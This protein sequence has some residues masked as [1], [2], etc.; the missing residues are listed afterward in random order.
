MSGSEYGANFSPDGRQVS[1]AWNGEAPSAETRPWWQG[2]WDIYV[3]LVGASELHRLTE[4]PGVDLA[5]VWSPD[6]REIAYVRL[7]PTSPQLRVVSSLG[8][9]D[10]QVSE[11]PVFLPAAWSPDGRYLVAGGRHPAGLRRAST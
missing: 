1:F 8:G 4:S 10:R 2:N 7:D 5:P 9:S 6:G 11:F 3:K